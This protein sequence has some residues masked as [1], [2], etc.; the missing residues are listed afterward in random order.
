[1]NKTVLIL[2]CLVL[3]I[4]P[5]VNADI[6]DPANPPISVTNIITNINQFPDYVF[7]QYG[8]IGGMPGGMCHPQVTSE[9]GKIPGGYKFCIFS[10]YAVKKSDFNENYLNS[11]NETQLRD[12]FS[13]PAVIEVIKNIDVYETQS[14]YSTERSVT[15][16]YTIDLN[17]V[18]DKPNKT[19]TERSSLIYLYMIIPIV[20]LAIIIFLLIRKYKK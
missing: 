7:V 6:I 17:Q 16:Y 1:M 12:Y 11:L 2:G 18:K 9:D 15:N 10:V 4:S 19:I 13:S 3:L 5:L 8:N 20:A 14:V